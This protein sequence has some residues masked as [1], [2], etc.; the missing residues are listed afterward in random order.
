[1]QFIESCSTPLRVLALRFLPP[2]PSLNVAS[3]GLVVIAIL[4][5]LFVTTFAFGQ[6]KEFKLTFDGKRAFGD[7]EKICEFGPR[8]SSS[9]GMLAQQKF[10]TDEFRKNGL[11]VEEQRFPYRHP[12]TGEQVSL[13]NL[14]AKFNPQS[15]RRLLLCAH[16]DTRPFPD[17]DPVNPEGVFL[18]ANDGAS[19]VALLLELSRHFQNMNIQ[20]GIDIVLFDAEEFVFDAARDPMFVG[21]NYFSKEYAANKR[22]QF[23][24]GGILVD[25]VGDAD[26][27]IGMEKNSL[28]FAGPLTRQVFKS[29]KD[30]GIKEFTQKPLHEIRDDHLPLNQIA[31]I[32]TIDLIDFDYPKPGANSYWHTMADVPNSCSA[33]SLE[34]VGQVLQHFLNNYRP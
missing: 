28:K 32:P 25:M 16:Y 5:N 30:L 1:M 31:R 29:A 17:N 13:V 26:L 3:N 6:P 27:E 19:G 9:E 33:A 4:L 21:S 22:T 11:V 23:Y 12:E 7:L 15:K 8:F 24:R 34:K 20:Y 2:F 14:I 10:L 18:G